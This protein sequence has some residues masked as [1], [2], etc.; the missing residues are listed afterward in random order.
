MHGVSDLH[1]LFIHSLEDALRLPL[2]QSE[3]V[4]QPSK[5][6]RR[7]SISERTDREIFQPCDEA[8]DP[9]VCTKLPVFGPPQLRDLRCILDDVL[10]SLT[11]TLVSGLSEQIERVVVVVDVT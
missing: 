11:V 2:Y 6:S 8:F 5:A 1:C 9:L 3:P 7:Y 4:E 10:S